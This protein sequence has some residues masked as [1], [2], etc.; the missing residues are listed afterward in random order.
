ML[1]NPPLEKLLAR[2][3]NRYTLSISIA[4]RAR[5]IQ[6][7]AKALID[8]S[9][10][11]S[12]LT[13]ACEEFVADK[14][15]ALPGKL[16]PVVPLRP[17]VEEALLAARQ[18]EEE[19]DEFLPN[20]VPFEEPE[21]APEPISKIRIMEPEEYFLMPYEEEE[22]ASTPDEENIDMEQVMTDPEED[23]EVEDDD[24]TSFS[25]SDDEEI[26]SDEELDSIDA[27]IDLMADEDEDEDYE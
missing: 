25:D 21:V 8:K 15:I 17:E 9:K 27:S 3:E 16:D 14:Y 12:T 24:T 5:Q 4:K 1:T 23:E 20:I 10:D 6:D 11:L 18:N 19:D 13:L 26:V 2:A 22:E 7:G